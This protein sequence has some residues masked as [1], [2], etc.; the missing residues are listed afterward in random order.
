MTD[1]WR[2][3]ICSAFAADAENFCVAISQ[4]EY[5]DPFTAIIQY[6]GRMRQPWSR[7][8]VRREIVS[9][10][11]LGVENDID[12]F[13]YVALSNEGDIYY[14]NDHIRRDLIPG[15]GVSRENYTGRGAMFA[16]S[17][18]QKK[19]FS[20]GENCQIYCYDGSWSKILNN[21]F[22]MEGYNIPSV[23]EICII[24]SKNIYFSGCYFPNSS[25]YD[26]FSDKNY[27]KDMSNEDIVSLITRNLLGNIKDST[28]KNPV[29][30]GLYY[31]GNGWLDLHL[32]KFPMV[33]AIYAESVDRIWMVGA[34]GAILLGNAHDGFRD[35]SFEGD[36]SATLLSITKFQDNIVIASEHGL[37]LFD[38]HYLSPIKPR[39]RKRA[40]K[41]FKVQTIDG[42]M[43]YFD[44]ALEIRRWNGIS[45]DEVAIPKELLQRKFRGL[46]TE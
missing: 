7:V 43:F 27:S 18:Y 40:P 13:T 46:N 34:N 11:S 31:N 3:L 6:N 42:V 17:S 30:F 45:W 29:G 28:K 16:V 32:D 4:L 15:A 25:V 39:L 41:P 44:Y 22:T 37:Y 36:R 12:G 23:D 35:L 1:I 2:P 21:K 10:H 24:N 19:L 5:D 38:G 14:I 33:K 20:A 9:I 8:D 26:V